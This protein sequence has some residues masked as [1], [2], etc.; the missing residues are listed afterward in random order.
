[1]HF[2]TSY[3]YIFF[4]IFYFFYPHFSIRHP[5]SAAIRSAFYRD[6]EERNSLLNPNAPEWQSSGRPR[7]SAHSTSVGTES[8]MHHLNMRE[9]DVSQVVDVQRL[10]QQQ[11]E[12]IQELL[13]Q[14]QQQTLAMT[15]PQPAVPIF[16]GDPVGYSDFLRAFE[17]LIESKTS[18]PSARLYYLVQFTSGDVKELMRSC[19]SIKP[20]EGYK[21]ARLLLKSHYGQSYKI[22]TSYV[23]R[24]VSAPQI[25]AE[26]GP[27]LQRYSVMLTSCKNALM[28]IDYLSKIENPGTMQK[29]I[30]RL[31]FGLRQKWCEKADSITEREKREVTIED[32]AV[33]IELKARA[34]NHPVFCSVNTD[35]KSSIVKNDSRKKPRNPTSK[36]DQGFAF[37]TQESLPADQMDHSS[38]M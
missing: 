1:M 2:Y 30:E 26:D 35:V 28:E 11:N 29:I 32:I 19:L 23:E 34:A 22:A 4:S 3:L 12:R 5:P 25:K 14:Q 15:L 33:F 6:P 37:V 24:V 13:K 18:D 36:T 7:P 31:P 8:V 9:T 20:D 27:A 16:S 10:Q 21:S 38:S 17:N